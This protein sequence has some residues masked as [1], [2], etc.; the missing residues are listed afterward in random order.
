MKKYSYPTLLIII[1]TLLPSSGYAQKAMTEAELDKWLNTDEP[2]EKKRPINEGKLSFLSTKKYS[3]VMHSDNIITI[4]KNSLKNGWVKL[5]QCYRNLDKFP[6][7]EVVYKY[8]AVKNLKIKSKALIQE[9]WIKKNSG[10]NSVELRRVKKGATI[11]V[12][13]DVKSLV[14][15]PSGQYSIS[16]GP[17]R[18]KFL[19]GYFPLRVSLAIKY[20]SRLIKPVTITPNKP[21]LN[22]RKKSKMILI[23]ATFE[24]VLNTKVSFKRVH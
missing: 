7:V 14:K 21:Q 12:S 10:N 9:A 6:A 18:R 11:C 8:K 23:D 20:P 1:S 17:F 5:N 4:N 15:L 3:A 2:V 24:G 13:A 19:D 22:I 16:N